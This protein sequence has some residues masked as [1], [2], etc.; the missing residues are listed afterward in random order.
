MG[1][2]IKDNR[3][4]SKFSNR[5][6]DTKQGFE[7]GLHSERDG[8]MNPST[9]CQNEKKLIAISQIVSGQLLIK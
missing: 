1:V 2:F 8:F 4:A 7:N 5:I 6:L 9:S 3:Y